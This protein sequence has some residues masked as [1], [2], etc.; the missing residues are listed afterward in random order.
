MS[1]FTLKSHNEFDFSESK[2]SYSNTYHLIN[3]IFLYISRPVSWPV[4]VTQL[5]DV[6]VHHKGWAF[7]I[8]HAIIISAI[9]LIY[10]IIPYSYNCDSNKNIFEIQNHL[11]ASLKQIYIYAYEMCIYNIITN[12]NNVAVR[13]TDITGDKLVRHYNNNEICITI[14]VVIIDVH[15]SIIN[16]NTNIYLP[17]ACDT[18]NN[19]ALQEHD[20]SWCWQDENLLRQG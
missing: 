13:Q 8:S 11:C 17:P 7:L 12:N 4:Q 2:L 15:Y 3:Y 20:T 18:R 1:L 16:N 9:S 6:C 10:E 14:F 19:S 5:F